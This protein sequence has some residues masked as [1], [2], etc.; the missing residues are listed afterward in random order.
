MIGLVAVTVAG[1]AAAARL[2]AAWPT[3]TRRYDGPAATALPEAFGDA[4]AVVV[5]LAVGATVRLLAP[6]YLGTIARVATLT[7]G[8]QQIES[9]L[10]LPA[11]AVTLPDEQRV[12]IPL[13]NL[14]VLE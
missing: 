13:V 2:A 5:F 3:E 11:A 12:W 9:G 14:E 4:D 6:P 8:R 10:N 7:Q 1:R